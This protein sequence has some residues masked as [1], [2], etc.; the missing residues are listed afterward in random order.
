MLWSSR[1]LKH[2]VKTPVSSGRHANHP[3]RHLSPLQRRARP[4]QTHINNTSQFYSLRRHKALTAAPNAAHYALAELA[5]KRPPPGFLTL[6][7]NV[8]G[9]SEAA[10]H[11]N[12]DDYGP[13]KSVEYLH[14]SLF[15][16][17]CARSWCRYER[18]DTSDPIEPS[19]AVPEG[20]GEENWRG[21]VPIE[22]L[23]RC[24]QCT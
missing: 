15:N 17:R 8:D 22:E 23:P 10:G 21:D 19:L 7:Q 9:L 20:D 11:N 4:P 6:T 14:G 3:L 2:S 1:R 16:V 24:P 13:W 5:R 12:N 18:F